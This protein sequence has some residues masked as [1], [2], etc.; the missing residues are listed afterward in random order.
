MMSPISSI[1]DTRQG[2]NMYVKMFPS[3]FVVDYCNSNLPASMRMKKIGVD[4]DEVE[5]FSS[6]DV[7]L[8]QIKNLEEYSIIVKDESSKSEI[9]MLIGDVDKNNVYTVKQSKGLEFYKTIVFSSDMSDNEKYIAYTRSL[10]KLV[11]VE[12]AFH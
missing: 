8:N 2:N 3:R 5:T 11:V 1:P 4:M 9:V 6:V 7:L 12:D 10:N